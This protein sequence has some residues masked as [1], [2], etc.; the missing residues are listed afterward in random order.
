MVEGL[1]K[2]QLK[3][4]SLKVPKVKLPKLGAISKIK[5]PKLRRHFSWRRLALV[6]GAIIIGVVGFAWLGG[7]SDGGSE[8]GDTSKT[9]GK[10]TQKPTFAVV[11][12]KGKVS[13][14][15][16]KDVKFDSARKSASYI[17]TLA[18]TKITVSQQEL[19]SRF[20]NDPSTSLK[21]FAKEMN[22]N[23]IINA[24][25]TTAYAGVSIKGPQTVILIKDKKLIFMTSD[26]EIAKDHWSNYIQSLKSTD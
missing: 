17:D 10:S 3:R 1:K 14:T 5:A 12:P 23:T 7:G 24:D 16:F 15:D 20:N 4:P 9:L 2:R 19:P 26:T 8:A 11:L 18:G 25:E 6:V 22:A 13:E 21:E